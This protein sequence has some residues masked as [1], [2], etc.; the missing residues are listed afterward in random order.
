MSVFSAGI[1][2][3][4]LPDEVDLTLDDELAQQDEEDMDPGDNLSEVMHQ[5]VGQDDRASSAAAFLAAA[6]DAL[7]AFISSLQLL[8]AS[9]ASALAAFAAASTT[10]LAATSA[11]ASFGRL[12]LR[13]AATSSVRRR[14]LGCCCYGGNHGRNGGFL[15]RSSPVCPLCLL[16]HRRLNCRLGHR[17]GGRL[18][19]CDYLRLLCHRLVAFMSA[20]LSSIF[21]AFLLGFTISSTACTSCLLGH[22]LLG[23]SLRS[24]ERFHL[25]GSATRQAASSLA[26]SST[27][28]STTALATASSAVA[29]YVSTR[30][31]S[32]PPHL[33]IGAASWAAALAAASKR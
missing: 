14:C 29:F 9:S 7:S 26:A 12:R 24:F 30:I 31:S 6:S 22:R 1:L 4:D 15:L 13:L 23:G 8:F 10:I 33:L 17:L 28:V 11:A 2:H 20:L 25:V 19:G 3:H 18:L 21:L 16:V 32:L 5:P 27:A